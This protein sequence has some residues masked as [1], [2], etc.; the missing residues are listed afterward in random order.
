MSQSL[1]DVIRRIVREEVLASRRTALA[2]VE[3]SH[4]HESSSDM[5]NYA[6]T[7]RLP[8]SDVTLRKVPVA[9]PRLGLVS[10]P[11][12]GDMV[13]VEFIGGDANAPVIVGT[14]YTDQD[15][16]PVS[17][18]GQMVLHLPNAGSDAD[19]VHLAISSGDARE[20]SLSLGSGLVLHLRDDDPA[21]ELEVDGGRAKVRIDR[22][23]ATHVESQGAIN[24]K[25]AEITIEASGALTLK[26]ATVDI[27]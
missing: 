26:G 15:R 5:D 18:E 27:N 21:V 25:G 4:P 12:P 19:A 10:V 8:D 6:C 24:I 3:Q 17:K 7:V 23:G 16:P 20:L 22:D 11:A 14:V 1:F 9:T 2:V 13:V